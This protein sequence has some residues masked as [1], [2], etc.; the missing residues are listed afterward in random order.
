[1]FFLY[2][3]RKCLFFKLKKKDII[4]MSVIYNDI[5]MMLKVYFMNLMIC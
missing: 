3:V 1:M 4:S 2:N 5:L